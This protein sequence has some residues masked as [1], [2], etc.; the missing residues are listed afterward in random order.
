[1]SAESVL[2]AVV[3]AT[4]A[5]HR[6]ST[7]VVPRPPTMQQLTHTLAKVARQKGVQQRV[8]TGVHV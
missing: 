4:G 7:A 1:M 8:Q 6:Q 3:V 2:V 5:H